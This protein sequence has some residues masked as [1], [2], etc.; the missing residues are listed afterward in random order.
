[1]IYEWPNNCYTFFVLFKDINNITIPE[2]T[3][4]LI[5]IMG[6]V[7]DTTGIL[8]LITRPYKPS[9]TPSTSTINLSTDATP[10]KAP[11]TTPQLENTS[12]N[13]TKDVEET[14]DLNVMFDS[15]NATNTIS[16]VVF[17]TNNEVGPLQ[18]IR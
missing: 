17:T 6:V 7:T 10:L 4:G 9:T 18:I 14:A 8:D 2:D 11:E 1:M 12:K 15:L 5:E 3:S 16:P 13:I